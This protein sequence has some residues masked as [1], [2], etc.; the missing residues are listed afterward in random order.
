M[1]DFFNVSM[2]GMSALLQGMASS[3]SPLASAMTPVPTGENGFADLLGLVEDLEIAE[4]QNGS[5]EEFLSEAASNAEFPSLRQLESARNESALALSLPLN[6][7]QDLSV[8]TKPLNVGRAPLGG[9]ETLD[10]AALSL[11]AEGMNREAL[12]GLASKSATPAPKG[13]AVAQWSAALASGDV[14]SVT[15][16]GV[17]VAS[18]GSGLER[19]LLPA[20]PPALASKPRTE[21]ND[22]AES[23]LPPLAATTAD[24][25]SA[26][27][28][29]SAPPVAS[30]PEPKLRER[31]AAPKSD[32]RETLERGNAPKREVAS[33]EPREMGSKDR[34]LTTELVEEFSPKGKV[35]DAKSF[36]LDRADL[37]SEGAHRGE[38]LSNARM[39][40]VVGAA[41]LGEGDRDPRVSGESIKFVADRIDQLKA[42][43]GGTIKVEL[44]PQSLGTIEVRVSMSRNQVRVQVSAERP[45]TLKALEAARLDLSSKLNEGPRAADLEFVARGST[46]VVRDALASADSFLDVRDLSANRRASD[47]Q[48]TS[49]SGGS[50][51]SE[52]RE[53]GSFDGFGR[54]ERRENA[55]DQW[56]SVF[57]R[58]KSA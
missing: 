8:A 54:E 52:R 32:V 55:R 47:V 19:G 31:S 23:A 11:E 35:R 38:Q 28:E 25:F 24:R 12:R 29:E 18:E 53:G 20:A 16:E 13:E 10:A 33:A 48:V 41:G 51:S 22:R 44:N 14:K 6:P 34:A 21:R 26:L 15:I 1:S 46:A 37:A 27:V 50:L 43:G 9:R 5:R 17:S 7:T 58:R 3:P 45:E 40:A 57:D 2:T 39:P 42:Q 56:E 30:N 4:G 36:L 49:T